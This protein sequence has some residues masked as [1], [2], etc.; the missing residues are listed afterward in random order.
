VMRLAPPL[1]ALLPALILPLLTGISADAEIGL[2][3]AVPR[4]SDPGFGPVP[5]VAFPALDLATLAADDAAREAS[6]QPYRFAI[7][8]PVFLSPETAGLWERA[9][10]SE[11]FGGTLRWRLRIR[12]EGAESLNLGFTGY[13]MP[14]GGRLTIYAAD[15]SAALDPFTAE[16]N[17]EHGQ[18]W[19]PVLATD[20]LVLDLVLPEAERGGLVLGLT[21]V[22]QGYRGFGSRGGEPGAEGGLAERISGSCNVDVACPEADPYRDITRS[23]ARITIAGAFLCS[24]AMV[25]NTA[26]DFRPLFLTADHC[27]VTGSNAASVVA[28]WLFEN[29]TCRPVGSSGGRGNGSLSQSLMGARL[30]ASYP[31]S[32]F[33]LIEFTRAPASSSRVYWAGWDRSGGNPSSAIAIHHP[34]GEEK[35]I[36]FENNPLQT[37]SYLGSSAPGNG[38]HLRVEDWDLGTTEGGSSGSPLFNPQKRIVGQLHGGFAACGNNSSDWYGRLSASWT[39][40]GTSGSRLRDWLDPLGTGASSVRG[41]QPGQGDSR[42][43]APSNLVATTRSDTEV[44][45]TWQDNSGNETAFRIEAR[46]GAGTFAEVG[47]AAAN[48]TS[49]IVTG[50][51]PETAYTFRVRARNGSGNSTYSNLATATTLPSMM[52]PPV[53]G[54]LTAESPAPTQ[55]LLKWVDVDDT[56]ED[57]EIE[58]RTVARLGSGGTTWVGAPFSSIATPAADTEAFLLS[59]LE[60][61][62]IYNFRIRAR[63]RFGASEPS[64]EATATTLSSTPPTACT[65]GPSNLCLLSGRFR[66]ETVWNNFRAGTQG[67]GGTV[68][69][70]SD[71]AGYFWFFNPANVELVVKVLDGSSLTGSFWFFYGA[72]SDV[73]YWITVTDT[74]DGNRKTYHNPPAEICGRGDT[75]ALP[76]NRLFGESAAAVQSPS[77]LPA[78]TG[79][80]GSGACGADPEAL[81]LLGRFDVRVDWAN[82]RNGA[83]GI[84]TPLSAGTGD[85]T[86]FFWFFN[87]ANVELVVKAV[88]GQVINGKFWFFYG[89]LSD[90]EYTITVTDTETGATV[91]YHNEPGNICGGADTDALD[92]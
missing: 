73:E 34:S 23:V 57:F 69:G 66:V 30:L 22:N 32:D 40:G 48:T 90:V 10:E 92:G 7:S 11:A 63:N 47:T 44:L 28:V 88:D 16:D 31:P 35:R 71:Q 87:P 50:L 19:T 53:P 52:A 72:L 78:T 15:G 75:D 58:M 18:L 39:G 4:A 12:A 46:E 49:M 2:R 25:N 65:E 17:A 82:Q 14:S 74:V 54:M 13:H 85:Q 83:T 79:I 21:A 77:A 59:G 37:T 36:S 89:A 5:I 3:P 33:S 81:C 29:S 60:A 38:T 64:A 43:A 84:G 61:D 70:G 27:G 6:G 20:D 42:P 9:G 8:H 41:A 51:S 56:E 24:G 45:L 1:K 55:M 91:S 76:A 86:G 80:K 68:P 67:T 26:E 62:A